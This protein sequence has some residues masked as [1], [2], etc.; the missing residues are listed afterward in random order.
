MMVWKK[1][2][3]V[4]KDVEEIPQEEPLQQEAEGSTS[5]YGRLPDR[6]YLE[7]EAGEVIHDDT[8]EVDEH[9]S[10]VDDN[11]GSARSECNN[12]QS[13]TSSGSD[14][15]NTSKITNEASNIIEQ[16]TPAVNANSSNANIDTGNPPPLI[17]PTPSTKSPEKLNR[18]DVRSGM[19]IMRAKNDINSYRRF[20]YKNFRYDKELEFT[21]DA[22][23]SYNKSH[24]PNN[25]W[26]P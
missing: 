21:S 19:A 6:T 4:T 14:S 2:A 17:N 16:Q 26:E 10:Y 9:T 13:S 15:S 5:I 1:K 20:F 7:E 24:H 11:L 18:V 3:K 25:S 8:N 12:S 23:L 22:V